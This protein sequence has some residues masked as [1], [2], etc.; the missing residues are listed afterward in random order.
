MGLV[1]DKGLG[2]LI[3]RFPVHGHSFL[4]CDRDFGDFKEK[5]KQF[6]WIYT[7]KSTAV[8]LYKHNVTMKTMVITF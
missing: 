7:P 1:V 2:E 4:S 5:I 8:T 3:H 6:D